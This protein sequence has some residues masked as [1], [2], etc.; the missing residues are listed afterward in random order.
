MKLL[1]KIANNRLSAQQYRN[2]L[3]FYIPFDQMLDSDTI[4]LKYGGFCK[5]IE[6]WNNDLD[7]KDDLDFELRQFNKAFME[8]PDGFTIH[9][10]TQRLPIRADY[11]N[12]SEFSPIPTVLSQKMRNKTFASS[13]STFYITKHYITISYMPL[14]TNDNVV[15]NLLSSKSKE[16]KEESYKESVKKELTYFNN[17]IQSILFAL[18]QA[19]R[20]HKVLQGSELLSYL[21]NT[22]NPLDEDR[23]IKMPPIGFHLDDYLSISQISHDG[24]HIKMNDQYMKVIT[25]NTYPSHTLPRVFDDLENLRFPLRICY[26]YIAMDKDES[27]KIANK[28][29]DYHYAKRHTFLSNLVK[30]VNGANNTGIPQSQM[31][32]DGDKTRI[33]KSLEA[34]EARDQIQENKVSYGYY[35]F[36]VI[37]FDER[38]DR[39]KKK[40]ELIKR[41]IKNHDFISNEDRFNTL[42]SFY[43]AVPGNISCNLRKV[44]IS[45]KVLAYLFPTSS[46]F[47]GDKWIEHFGHKRAL[48]TTSSDKQIFYFN[49]YMGDLGH[50][51]I[52]GMSG[53]GKSV[54]LGNMAMNFL[55]YKTRIIKKDGSTEE[56][57]SQ[58]FFF[59]KDSSSRV[60]TRTCGGKF[61]DIGGN[62]LSFQ[63]LRNVHLDR[64]KEF[65]KEWIMSLIEQEDKS[66]ISVRTNEIV[67]NAILQLSTDDEIDRTVSTLIKYIQDQD[68]K[69]ALKPYSLEGEYGKYF[70]NNDDVL[71]KGQITTFEMGNIMDKPKVLLPTL[72]YLFHKIETEMLTEGVATMIVLDECWLFLKSDKFSAKIEDW[73]RVLRK[74]NACVVFATQSLEDIINSKISHVIQNNCP[75]KIFLPNRYAMTTY[76]DIY[77]RFNL[78]DTSLAVLANA[79]P[80]R[81][82]LY[83]KTPMEI[84]NTSSLSDIRLFELN[85]S[86]IEL[87]YTAFSDIASQNKIDDL[88][89][90]SSS[91]SDLNKKWLLYLYNE[92]KLD[93]DHL[94]YV[95]GDEK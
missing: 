56:R 19:I 31:E 7:Y 62:S 71:E 86:D 30:F 67:W 24:D 10:E 94:D 82:Y 61:Y 23:R 36:S 29:K 66:L 64:E 21:Y 83:V 65:A 57:P 25:I 72:D 37:V 51:L 44:P 95:F 27:I 54:L 8:I 49:N 55:K 13:D 38:L 52:T 53:S 59:D 75:T 40:V 46:I 15:E 76:K 69:E 45:T 85:L 26:R 80:K 9:Y 6:V 78:S 42:D 84:G 73:L 77:K 17:V 1:K 5:V 11:E 63:P 34:E 4:M 92:G 91:I 70:D 87:A 35:T 20:K 43:G 60:L 28:Y 3:R 39:I 47:Q 32:Y 50:T 14:E 81:E 79:I 16:D 2:S 48:M 58:V 88:A 18:D 22:V 12:I 74:K 89:E 33:A 41:L 68:L 90:T 93:K